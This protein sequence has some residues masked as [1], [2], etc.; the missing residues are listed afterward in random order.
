MPKSEAASFPP[1]RPATAFMALAN[2]AAHDRILM[3]IF[4]IAFLLT[5]AAKLLGAI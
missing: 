2:A 5:A 4:A 1:V 3:Y